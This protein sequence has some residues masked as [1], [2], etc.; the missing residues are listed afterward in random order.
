[1]TDE[2]KIV[3]LVIVVILSTM[4]LKSFFTKLDRDNYYKEGITS[5]DE[6]SDN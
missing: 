5:D 6:D 4:W 2:A 1:M 3:I